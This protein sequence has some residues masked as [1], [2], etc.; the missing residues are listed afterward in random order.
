MLSGQVEARTASFISPVAPLS[1]SV[2][3]V[4]PRQPL[5]VE[6]SQLWQGEVQDVVHL[7]Q[8]QGALRLGGPRSSFSLVEEGPAPGACLCRATPTGFL[9]P[10]S[11]GT[12]VWLDKDGAR[13][14]LS[15]LIG[16]AS[17]EHRLAVGEAL[18]LETGALSYRLRLVSAAR[19]AARAW[20]DGLDYP[21]LAIGGAVGLGAALFSAAM[22]ATPQP[23][24]SLLEA[25]EMDRFVE[26]LR[27]AIT[28]EARTVKAAPSQ[29]PAGAKAKGAQ[30]KAGA[31]KGRAL[32]KGARTNAE[33]VREAGILGALQDES[34][35]AA[36]NS[37]ALS[38]ELS[39]GIGGLIGAKGTQL[40]V[41]GLG[42]RGTGIGGG[43]TTEGIGGV[44]T[45][46]RGAGD[47]GYGQEGGGIGQH[48][49]GHI[50]TPDEMITA[51]LLDRSLIDAVVK[52]SLNRVRHCYQRELN[53]KPDLAGKISIKFVIAS[54]GTVSRSAVNKSTMG[55]AGVE[56]CI[57]ERFLTMKFPEPKGGGIVTVNY[58][59]LFAPAR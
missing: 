51:G 44:N 33:V 39:S 55:D 11:L 40:G 58:P 36:F 56:A 49:E 22:Y 29:E 10:L 12:Q 21:M 18:W 14:S 5:H 35:A 8:G 48:R 32:A 52:R 19:T 43:G 54:D 13:R 3:S 30:G 7:R 2:E 1:E 27:P 31:P 45:K 25:P 28:P 42:S 17:L 34:M 37:S 57:A 47:E 26:L 38:T 59:F 9:V 6:V 15:R 4:D 24:P 16:A 20:V 53:R 41:G 23:D 50:T 46:G